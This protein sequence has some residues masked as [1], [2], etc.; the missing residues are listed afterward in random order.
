MMNMPVPLPPHCQDTCAS[1]AGRRPCSRRTGLRVRAEP[2]GVHRVCSRVHGSPGGERGRVCFVLVA[3]TSGSRTPVTSGG[4]RD[5][6]SQLKLTEACPTAA[7][8]GSRYS[9]P[10]AERVSCARTFY[11]VALRHL[12]RLQEKDFLGISYF[13]HELH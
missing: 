2:L 11:S 4:R 5:P 7:R 1:T 3:L 6:P 12:C 10:A 9:Q 8:T 13:S